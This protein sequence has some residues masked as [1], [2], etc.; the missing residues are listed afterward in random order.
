M[1]N[2]VL[3]PMAIRCSLRQAG[4]EDV[5]HQAAQRGAVADHQDG[6]AWVAGEDRVDCRLQTLV[7]LAVGLAAAASHVLAGEHRS[8]L[9]GKS[10]DDVVPG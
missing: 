6:L 3:P 9:L 1:L 5:R 10:L 2:A 8:H 4:A 7:Q